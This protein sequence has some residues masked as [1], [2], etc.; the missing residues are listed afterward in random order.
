M[1]G[2]LFLVENIKNKKNTH[3]YMNEYYHDLVKCKQHFKKIAKELC[4]SDK[5]LEAIDNAKSEFEV[6]QIMVYERR[7]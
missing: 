1:K 2:E 3:G 5:V 6:E 4:Y 7:K